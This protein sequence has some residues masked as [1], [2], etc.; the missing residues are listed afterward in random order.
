MMAVLDKQEARSLY[1]CIAG[2]YDLLLTGFRIIELERERKGL[3]EDMALRPGEAVVDLC[4]GR[5]R[6]LPH[7]V[8]AIGQT[9]KVIAVDLSS[10]ML[11]RAKAQMVSRVGPT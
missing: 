1:D 5:G 7:T 4:C 6:N 8:A 10:S 9:G 3:I 11:V 2:R